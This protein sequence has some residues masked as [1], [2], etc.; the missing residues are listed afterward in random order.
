MIQTPALQLKFCLKIPQ[1]TLKIS[2]VTIFSKILLEN[3]SQSVSKTNHIESYVTN[4]PCWFPTSLEI[5][6]F[7]PNFMHLWRN[8]DK[9][10]CISEQFQPFICKWLTDFLC[11][12]RQIGQ[13]PER[14]TRATCLMET[15]YLSRLIQEQNA[16]PKRSSIYTLYTVLILC[17]WMKREWSPLLRRLGIKTNPD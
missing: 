12:Q 8:F 16:N 17:K 11:K 6:L 7:W 14:Q 15:E 10:S 4:L 3:I 9:I 5:V 2:L 13:E 1:N